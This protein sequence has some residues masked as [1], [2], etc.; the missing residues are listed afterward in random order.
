MPT[1][2]VDEREPSGPAENTGGRGRRRW[3]VVCGIVLVAVL[4]FFAVTAF[5]GLPVAGMFQRYRVADLQALSDRINEDAGPYRT[6][7][8]CWRML[9][10]A[11]GP[12]RPIAGVDYLRSRVVVRTYAPLAGYTEA[13]TFNVIVN[14]VDG[15]IN[16]DSAFSWG[17]VELE[18]SPDGWSPLVSCSLVTQ[19]Y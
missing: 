10:G 5:T 3:L 4:I 8:D 16:S 15:V 6:P 11:S 12:R 2:V 13:S 7:D 9:N 18:P 19:G 17:M 14:R 1:Q